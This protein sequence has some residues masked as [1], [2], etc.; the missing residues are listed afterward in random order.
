MCSARLRTEAFWKVGGLRGREGGREGERGKEGG[1]E[2]QREGGTEGGRVYYREYLI[3]SEVY[4]TQKCYCK[5][6]FPNFYIS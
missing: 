2:G 5:V 4:E 6:F 3:L 1:R